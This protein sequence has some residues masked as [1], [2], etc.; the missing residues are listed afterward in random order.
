MTEQFAGL[1]A[2]AARLRRIV[3]GLHSEQLRL[4]AYPSEWSIAD[5]LS[6]VGAGAVIMGMRL[7]TALG[8]GALADD[9]PQAIWDEWNVKTPDEKAADALTA[10]HALVARLG[11]I[12]GDGS[13][14]VRVS[15]GPIELDFDTFVGLRLNEHV[16]HTWDIEVALEPTAI[17]PAD[18]ARFVV[19]NLA[20]IVGF[21][22]KPT[23]VVHDVHIRT[24]D[25]AREFTLSLR[26]KTD[27]LS[28][29]T[30]TAAPDLELPA[31]ALVRLV[32]G[33]LD[34]D[35]MPTV[36][37]DADLAELRRAFPGV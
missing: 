12:I 7:D 29:A 23:G 21:V 11:S 4:P 32:Y 3:E 26:A 18:A 35:H 37:G 2:S 5:V 34:A 10:D 31:E 13:A 24:T 19:D 16:L 20:M 15:L 1:Q 22:G 25:P 17:V 36:R 14:P 27:S 9:F 8:A 6:H 33:R 30:N 28:P